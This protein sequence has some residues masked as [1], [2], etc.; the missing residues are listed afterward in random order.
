MTTNLIAT[1]SYLPEKC[2][3]NAELSTFL[4]TS[5]EWIQSRTGIATR[6]IATTETTTDMAVTAAK[7]ALDR[8]GLHG[9]DLD[10]IIVATVSSDTLVPSTACQVQAALEA[11]NAF[12][13]DINAACSGFVYATSI[14]D[15][16]MRSGSIR[17]ALIIGVETLSKLMDWNDRSCC[18][19]FGDGCGAAIFQS[20]ASDN[21]GLLS[22]VH[23][24][25]GSRHQVLTC[26]SRPLCNHYVDLDAPHPY[27][28]MD[29][30]EVFKFAVKKVPQVI[31]ET[32]EQAGLT[33]D[34]IDHFLLHQANIRIIQ[35][36]A[37]KLHI[38][39]ERFPINL[40]RCGNTSAASLGILLDE[41][42]RNGTIK[43]GDRILLAGFGA[44]LTWG[45]LILQL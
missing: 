21:K 22:C 30:Q 25:D 1:G 34:D 44:G 20:D 36:I 23:H 5:D 40:D 41:C 28:Y 33:V 43:S 3:T 32:L 16:F 19:L 42:M 10:L 45:G 37:K 17:T 7:R 31:E 39:L 15:Q 29:G 9:P 26:S 18:I 2:M 14:A 6:H 13:F 8:A 11:D 4:D 35:S 38:P 12:A 24:S 27:L